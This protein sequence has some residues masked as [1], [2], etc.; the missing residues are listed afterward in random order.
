MAKINL[1][2]DVTKKRADGYHEV[3][4]V[5][6]TIR[7]YD[8][9]DMEI[10]QHSGVRMRT[11]LPY[12]PV[13]DNNLVCRAAKMLL[14]EF[15]IKKGLDIELK[16]VIP[17]A[18]GMAG[19]S[20]DAAAT[21]VGVNRIFRLGLSTKELMERAVTIGAD[22]PYCIMRGT[23]L[24]E[25][26]GDEL[27]MLPKAPECYV[28]I[29]KPGIS[30]STKFVYGNLKVAEIAKHPDIDAIV[31]AIKQNDFYQMANNIGNVL[32]EVTIP[33]YPIIDKIKQEMMDNGAVNALMSGSGPTVFGLFDDK[34]KAEAAR[35]S[36][37]ES[38]NAKQ[39]FLTTFFNTG[40]TIDGN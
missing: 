14:D 32:E 23:A 40:G 27:T 28:L 2:L 19:G 22:V 30:V 25:G 6:Q 13:N 20:T 21:M 37:R 31:T 1:G 36:L 8:Q 26:I 35:K 18:A 38:R 34:E 9:I 11:N 17:V 4:M 29:G 33:A 15:D 5:M 24:A 16:K 10:S 3:K 39:V 7:M 12:L